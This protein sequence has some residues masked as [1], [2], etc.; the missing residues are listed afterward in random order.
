MNF[1]QTIEEKLM[2]FGQK[3][4]EKMHK[5]KTEIKQ[6][7][8]DVVKLHDDKIVQPINEAVKN[9]QESMKESND[10][11]AKLENTSKNDY[12][13]KPKIIEPKEAY[14]NSCDHGP[15]ITIQTTGAK[16]KKEIVVEF[17]NGVEFEY[18]CKVVFYDED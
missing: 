11:V 17:D 13:N 4:D 14:Q 16:V 7:F 1:G 10:D 15:K 9:Y 5:G 6:E 8:E 12:I 2:K 18:E 3:V